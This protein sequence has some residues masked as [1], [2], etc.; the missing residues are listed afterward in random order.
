MITALLLVFWLTCTVYCLGAGP[1][2]FLCFFGCQKYSWVK[3]RYWVIIDHGGSQ[4]EVP[5]IHE[6]QIWLVAQYEVGLNDY[7]RYR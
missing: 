1:G 6:P 5:G 4:K 3:Q 7:L 2:R